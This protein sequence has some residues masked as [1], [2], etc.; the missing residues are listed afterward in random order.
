MA[1]GSWRDTPEFTHREDHEDPRMRPSVDKLVHKLKNLKSLKDHPDAVR[2]VIQALAHQSFVHER[3]RP[4]DAFENFMAAYHVWQAT[5]GYPPTYDDTRND[6][7]L[8]LAQNAVTGDA[9]SKSQS[10]AMVGVLEEFVPK[11]RND[12][13]PGPS[14]KSPIAY[15]GNREIGFTIPGIN[16]KFVWKGEGEVPNMDHVVEVVAAGL[17]GRSPDLEDKG[18]KKRVRLILQ[19]HFYESQDD[20]KEQYLIPAC[21]CEETFDDLEGWASHVRKL[22]WKELKS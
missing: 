8:E 7:Q 20:A 22:I 21:S 6:R 12:Q 11:Q 17:P 14:H 9:D 15:S 4:S 10:L 1:K 13:S 16:G 18:L 5:I 19:D 2:H 3:L